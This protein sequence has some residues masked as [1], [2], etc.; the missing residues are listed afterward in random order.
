M[1]EKNY[2][3][4][5]EELLFELRMLAEGIFDA[6]IEDANGALVFAFENGQK[7]ILEVKES[8]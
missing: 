3:V 6:E 4:E 5:K 7:F 2:K 1:E 8:S